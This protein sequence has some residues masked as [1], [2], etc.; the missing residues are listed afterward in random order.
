MTLCIATT[1]TKETE[2]LVSESPLALTWVKVHLTKM[3]ACLHSVKV[4][5]APLKL[6][7]VFAN[8][9]RIWLRKDV[10]FHS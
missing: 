1:R 8:L 4:T 9:R 7:P 5:P 2:E 6:P 10:F 3:D